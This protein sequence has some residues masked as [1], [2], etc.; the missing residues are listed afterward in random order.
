MTDRDE[1]FE[2]A[3]L[4]EKRQWRTLQDGTVTMQE[5]RE[6]G[7]NAPAHG[8]YELQLA[9]QVID[10]QRVKDETGRSVPGCRLR[11]DRDAPSGQ[12]GPEAPDER[13]LTA[14][15]RVPGSEMR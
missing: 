15:H 8:M 11:T 5:L 1:R 14:R 2:E 13:H 10:R 12:A 4:N 3:D 6:R 7:V 9:G